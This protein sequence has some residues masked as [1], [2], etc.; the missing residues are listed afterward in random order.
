MNTTQTSVPDFTL[1]G[2]EGEE[3]TEY[4]LSD[5]T[6]DGAVVLVSYPFDFRPV[7]TDVLCDFRDAEFLVFTD[8]VDVFGPS[9]DCCYAHKR[10]IQEYDLPFPLL[11]DPVGRVTEQLGLAYNEREQ[12][13]G[14]P[15]R[16]IMTIDGSQTVRYKWS[17][18]DA[19]ESPS[20]DD[21][22]DAVLALE[23]TESSGEFP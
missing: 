22:H 15:K 19:Y 11:S 12:H 10:F 1:P 7:C 18:E 4:Q 17:T 2:T 21:L 8:D 3:I 13:E 5:H 6:D 14:V 9:L 20:L 16:S 23:D